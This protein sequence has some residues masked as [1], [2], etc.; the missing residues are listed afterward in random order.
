MPDVMRDWSYDAFVQLLM[1]ALVAVFLAKNLF[2]L[3]SNYFQ[4]R[5]QFSVS[6]RIYQRLF[7]VYISQPYEF[8]LTNSSSVL[9]RNVSEFS[10]AVVGSGVIPS[11]SIL[12]ELTTGVGL[13]GILVTLEPLATTALVMFFGVSSGLI[14]LV[15]RSKTRQWG[16]AR[17]IF[18]GRTIESLMSGFGAIKEIKLF[19]RAQEV[20][21]AHHDSLYQASRVSYLFSLAQAVPRALFEVMAVL[22]VALLIL[23]ATVND[24]DLQDATVI[25]ALFGVVA[26]RMLPS[27]NKVVQA[28]QVLSF[29]RSGIEGAVVG[30]AMPIDERP[31]TTRKP[32]DRFADLHASALKYRYPNTN[33]LVTD[34]DN[35]TLRVGE[36]LGIVGA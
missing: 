22:S 14:I 20:I 19:G 3:V 10:A 7:K 13:L 32:L 15:L 28:M 29:G 26:F 33:A 36:S 25:I 34:I 6:N 21:G 16:S 4:Q 23:I 2:L 12:T 5:L 31:K 30:L 8:H 9:I 35:L 1:G 11:L 18:R 27:V 24:A 17:I